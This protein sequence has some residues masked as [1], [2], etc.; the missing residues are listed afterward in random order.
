MGV[1]YQ[2]VIPAVIWCSHT[3]YFLNDMAVGTL[4]PLMKSDL[5]TS[6]AQ[7]LEMT[8]ASV[9]RMARPEEMTDLDGWDK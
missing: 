5:G 4:A 9:N 7:F 1:S 2:W 8:T 6:V 3:I